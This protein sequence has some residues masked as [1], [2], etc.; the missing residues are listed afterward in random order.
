MWLAVTER[1]AAGTFGGLKLPTWE[2]PFKLTAMVMEEREIDSARG[3]SPFLPETWKRVDQQTQSSEHQPAQQDTSQRVSGG[4]FSRSD[5]A[6]EQPPA[7]ARHE[8]K[9]RQK[10]MVQLS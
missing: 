5:L 3:R 10:L 7:E 6:R 8:I 4:A 9:T 1:A 2:L